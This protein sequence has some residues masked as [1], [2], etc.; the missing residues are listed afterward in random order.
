MMELWPLQ[1]DRAAKA[2]AARREQEEM[3]QEE[4]ARKSRRQK[5]LQTPAG[6]GHKE[7]YLCLMLSPACMLLPTL[8]AVPLG[9]HHHPSMQVH[10]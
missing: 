1:E 3:E 7:A 6:K 10:C 9:D 4:A 2:E 8:H 5:R